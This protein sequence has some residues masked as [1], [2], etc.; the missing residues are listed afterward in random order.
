LEGSYDSYLFRRLLTNE[1]LTFGYGGFAPAINRAGLGIT[2][3][4]AVLREQTLAP[5]EFQLD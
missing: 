3:N 5:R 2:I 1:D 4:E